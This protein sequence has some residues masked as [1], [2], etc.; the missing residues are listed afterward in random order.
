MVKGSYGLGHHCI[1]DFLQKK[2]LKCLQWNMYAILNPFIKMC[3]ETRKIHTSL[4]ALLVPGSG[5]KQSQEKS[6]KQSGRG[7]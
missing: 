5:K 6:I 3:T 2:V 4:I 7:K 1:K